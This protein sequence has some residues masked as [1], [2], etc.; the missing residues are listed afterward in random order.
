MKREQI[1]RMLKA[2]SEE[3]DKLKKP[4]KVV[5]D[6]LRRVAH[7]LNGTDKEVPNE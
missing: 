4:E 6:K 1:E 3:N 2:C 7:E 5:L